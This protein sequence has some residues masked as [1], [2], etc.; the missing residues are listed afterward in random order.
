MLHGAGYKL[1]LSAKHVLGLGAVKGF[2]MVSGKFGFNIKSPDVR[3]T[4]KSD[5]YQQCDLGQI[6]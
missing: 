2:G 5:T 6:T 4:S 1:L 3:R